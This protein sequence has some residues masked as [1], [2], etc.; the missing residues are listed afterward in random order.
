[1]RDNLARRIAK[2][3]NDE[4]RTGIRYVVSSHMLS[5]EEWQA[6]LGADIMLVTDERDGDPVL[7]EAEW[8]ARHCLT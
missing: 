7:T 5:H 4:A 3:E 8:V 6:R 1:M 2:L